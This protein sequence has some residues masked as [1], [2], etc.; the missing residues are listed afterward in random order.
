MNYLKLFNLN[1][2]TVFVT[3]GAGWLGS[4]MTEALAEF[5]ANVVIASRDKNNCLK[6][7]EALQKIYPKVKIVG[8]GIDVT[9]TVSVR[10]CFKNIIKKSGGINILIN[11]AY[12]AKKNRLA[13]MTDKEWN[14]TMEGCLTSV[15]RCTR[16]IIP[17]MKKQGGGVIINIA[18]MYGIVAPDPRIY[19]NSNFYNP[20]N[21]GTAKSGVIQFTKYCAT[22]LA[23]D[24][25][26]V[27]AISPGPFPFLE[28]RKFKWFAQELK[29]KV[30][31]GRLGH[32][33]DLKGAIVFLC[34]EASSYITGH[35]LVVDGGWTV[36]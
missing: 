23:S 24:G 7:A 31:L 20:P 6:R 11:N 19:R 21:Y 9:S 30:P 32:P 29:N 17:Y 15:F 18:S 16:E 26:R 34:S 25:I 2:K 12:D 5:G 35:N 1:N 13:D 28:T 36:W 22:H 14:Y 10:R 33:Q 4:A 3:G 8:T 27:N